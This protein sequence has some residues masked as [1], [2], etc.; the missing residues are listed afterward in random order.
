MAATPASPEILAG[1]L[2]LALPGVYDLLQVD[3]DGTALKAANLLANEPANPDDGAL[4]A[5]RTT[6]LWLTRTGQGD[7]LQQRM[8]AANSNEQEAFA[9][10]PPTPVTL[11]A[12]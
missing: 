7:A 3:Q 5:I 10:D 6:G 12:E 4:P 11:F 2:N 9:T 1:L 8:S